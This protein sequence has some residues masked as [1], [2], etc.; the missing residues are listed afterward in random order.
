MT[1]D[2]SEDDGTVSVFADGQ[3]LTRY[4]AEHEGSK[5]GFDVVALPPRAPNRPGENLVVSSPHDHPDNDR[6]PVNW[7][8]MTEPFGFLAASPTWQTVLTLEP[9]ESGS[10]TWGLRVHPGTPAEERVGEAYRELVSLT[11]ESDSK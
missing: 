7:F 1:L 5:P 9:G 8:I 3:L 4:D 6:H 10:W 11:D 2:F